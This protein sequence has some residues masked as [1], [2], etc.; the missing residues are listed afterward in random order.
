[1]QKAYFENLDS[2][3]KKGKKLRVQF[4][5][6][7][8]SFNKTAQFAEIAI[9]GLDAPVLQFIR[10]GTETLNLEL[11]F[12]TTDEGMGDSA[13]SVTEKV[14]AFYELVK[15][16]PDTHA[17]PVCRFSWG[18]PPSDETQK[19]KP[20]SYAPFYFTCVVESL[21]RKFLLFSPDGVPLRARVSV[22]L[23]EY[24]T[25][26]QMVAN[27]NS[28]DRTKAHVLKRRERLDQLSAQEY[29]SPAEWRRIAEANDIEDPRRVAPGTLLKLPPH[30]VESVTRRPR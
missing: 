15:Q 5:P 19:K 13:K 1:M 9:P 3:T 18:A 10:G 22:K 29:D 23:R 20:V 8:L 7:D 28:A 14:N 25:V 4:N 12:D 16:D 21:D 17:V 24:Q 27:L 2:K 30:R 26:E 6:T 11:F